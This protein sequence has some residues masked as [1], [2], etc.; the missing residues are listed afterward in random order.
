VIVG[1]LSKIEA[2]VRKLNLGEVKVLDADGN[3]VR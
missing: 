2:D 3:V 1:D